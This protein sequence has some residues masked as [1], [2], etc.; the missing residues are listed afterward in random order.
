MRFDAMPLD[1]REAA[2]QFGG[3]AGNRAAGETVC[4]KGP[5][6]KRRACADIHGSGVG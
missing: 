2:R 5:L 6:K 3:S 4:D 1:L